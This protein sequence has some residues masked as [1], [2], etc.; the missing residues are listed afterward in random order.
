MIGMR[1]QKAINA[2][3]SEGVKRTQTGK[4]SPRKGKS[5]RPHADESKEKNRQAT[6]AYWDRRGR[7]T[8]Q[9]RRAKNVAGVQ[10][11]RAR[12]Y[13][14]I[15]PT[16]DLKLIQMIYIACPEGYHVDHIVSLATGGPHHQDNLQYLPA[17]ENRRKNKSNPYDESQVIR[18]K[19]VLPSE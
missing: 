8:E 14:A 1:D 3:I 4:P 7:Q 10:K 6:I 19:D 9:E 18:W 2:K 15:L 5:W 13:N 12:K 16:S 17:Y 11:Y